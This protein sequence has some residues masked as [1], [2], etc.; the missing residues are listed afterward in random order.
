MSVK[1]ASKS[2]LSDRSPKWYPV[3]VCKHTWPRT[4]GP[5]H[6]VLPIALPMGRRHGIKFCPPLQKD[7]Q[8]TPC[9]SHRERDQWRFGKGVGRTGVGI[10]LPQ[11]SFSVIPGT[12]T[13][14][15]D[16]SI[17]G[18]HGLWAQ[19]CGRAAALRPRSIATSCSAALHRPINVS[20]C[21]RM[22]SAFEAIS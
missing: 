22:C 12:G 7:P 16:A 4:W 17:C 2:V 20:A 15:A 14:A 1:A 3:H 11:S 18:R 9:F 21:C 13:G 6:C 10:R 19:T 8:T 5:H